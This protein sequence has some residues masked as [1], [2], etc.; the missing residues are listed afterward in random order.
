MGVR[1]LAQQ[2]IY[3]NVVSW[4]ENEYEIPEIYPAIFPFGESSGYALP[5]PSEKQRLITGILF[6]IFF[7]YTFFRK[8][9]FKHLWNEQCCNACYITFM[10]ICYTYG[11][12]NR[13]EDGFENMV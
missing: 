3:H 6:L 5:I 13:S 8:L 4:E 12:I 10:K 1:C 9:H 2:M 7:L 11:M